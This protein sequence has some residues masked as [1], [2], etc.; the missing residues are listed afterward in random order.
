MKSYSKFV[1][2][3]SIPIWLAITSSLCSGACQ[4]PEHQQ[5][6]KLTVR[7]KK[8]PNPVR[9]KLTR[10]NEKPRDSAHEFFQKGE[11]LRLT[12]A[13]R[14]FRE[15]VSLFSKAAVMYHAAQDYEHESTA[16]NEIGEIWFML[17]Y[18]SRAIDAHR[19]ALT[20]S[21]L[22]K[23][24][25]EESRAL[26]GLSAAFIY[27]G[28]ISNAISDARA[29][30]RI[31]LKASDVKQE[32]AAY[33]NLGEAFHA[34]SSDTMA[35][36]YLT[37]SLDISKD[38]ADK[39]GEAYAEYALG[40]VLDDMGDMPEAEDREHR[41]LILWNDSADL[42]GQALAWK[43]IGAI[44]LNKGEL[45]SALNAEL[46]ALNLF[47]SIGDRLGEASTDMFLGSAMEQLGEPLIALDFHRR[48]LHLYRTAASKLGEALALA[49]IGHTYNTMG[50]TVEAKI[51][52][53][54]W[55]GLSF[56]L[57]D[58]RQEA[59][60]LSQL[61]LVEES[62]H[63]PQTA[64][65]LYRQALAI[66]RKAG[67]A[68][69][70]AE[71]LLRLGSVTIQLGSLQSALEY[72]ADVSRLSEGL[73]DPQVK[74]TALFELGRIHLLQNDLSN[75]RSCLEAA[76]D[77]IESERANVINRQERASFFASAHDLYS[78]YIEVLMRTYQELG[79]PDLMAISLEVSERGRARSL[80]DL[81]AEYKNPG[82]VDLTLL[83][84][85]TK[86]RDILNS[87]AQMQL[88]LQTTTH[89]SE[90]VDAAATQVR[91]AAFEYRQ[92]EGEIER[93]R[94]PT[95]G[96]AVLSV[97]EMQREI[98]SSTMLLE[99]SLGD[100][101][102]YLWL[103]GR[104]YLAVY[105]IPSRDKIETAVR[106]ILPFL[107][108]PRFIGSTREQEYWRY[109][110]TLS[111][112]LLA[113]VVKAIQ[114]KRLVLIPDGILNYLPFGA[115]S[116][117]S[118]WADHVEKR[119]LAKDHDIV[120]IS[121]ASVGAVLRARRTTY[122]PPPKSIM[123]YADPVFDLKDPRVQTSEKNLKQS[124]ELS[125]ESRL[126]RAFPYSQ[127]WEKTGII[128]RL[129]ATRDEAENIQKIFPTGQADVALDFA[130]SRKAVLEGELENYRILH[131]ATHALV[132]TQIPELSGVILSLVDENGRAEDGFLRLDD[133]E[134]LRLTADLVVLSACNTSLGRDL[135][136]EG[137]VSLSQGFL[138]AGASSV[139]ST[140]WKVD[141]EASAE[142]VQRFYLNIINEKQ[143]PAMA[144]R[145]AQTW[146]WEQ[147]RWRAPYYWAAFVIEG[148][149]D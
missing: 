124:P 66:S 110:N 105:Q 2:Y 142:L 36:A 133:A 6:Q 111:E 14:S 102:S 27:A 99:Y 108:S 37:K 1:G 55:V 85:E 47:K 44:A 81:V 112:M 137:I 146:M 73:N 45:Q 91:D 16:R 4:K 49:E 33:K 30:L 106:K 140:L 71:A 74:A 147:E 32:I 120:I 115:L 107:T 46:L 92:V 9:L 63:Q 139:M 61:G 51:Y 135:K 76:I 84:R 129:P 41:A 130:A 77:I 42:R 119:P 72:L 13:A 20:F 62:E 75:A 5:R 67:D 143:S 54:T 136:G 7:V 50:S 132:D 34:V 127:E 70:Q 134:N 52:S 131:F 12:G 148:D 56:I 125:I 19:C 64:A 59:M 118:S 100:F 126:T 24:Q 89:D 116:S 138:R 78:L 144:L 109:A 22:S 10:A 11:A 28:Q 31:S 79:T 60:A 58:L 26:N 53:K 8:G 95:R 38:C 48:A 97:S 39:N 149:W 104:N 68:R 114:G 122:A 80:L 141:D 57:R 117:P 25:T 86:L 93:Q 65:G 96:G 87:R 21:R 123:V 29:A 88:Q 121:S 23:N 40:Y 113:P 82:Q 3:L 15:A 145:S 35:V 128:P 43:E 90:A 94:Y 69:A 101:R 18:L 103:V 17:G 83:A 98:D